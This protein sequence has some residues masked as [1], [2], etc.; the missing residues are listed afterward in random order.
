LSAKALDRFFGW[1]V[2]ELL[3]RYRKRIAGWF[4]G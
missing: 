2:R 1:E 4:S 3:S